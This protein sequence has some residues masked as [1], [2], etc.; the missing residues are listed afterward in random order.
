[1]CLFTCVSSRV[2]KK[3]RIKK[4]YLEVKD[5][6]VYIYPRREPAAPKNVFHVIFFLS[7][8]VSSYTSVCLRTLEGLKEYLEGLKERVKP[9][10][11]RR[12]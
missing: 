6:F 8:R 1:M 2:K 11:S 4:R 12:S 9:V 7:A 10:K 5:T 3:K